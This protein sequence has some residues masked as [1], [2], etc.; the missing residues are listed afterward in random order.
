MISLLVTCFIG[1][2]L[3]QFSVLWLAMGTGLAVRALGPVGRKAETGK[4]RPELTSR[5]R[6]GSLLAAGYAA[7]RE[8]EAARRSGV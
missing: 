6:P 7:A 1:N 2:F 8:D 3:N 5:G 4:L